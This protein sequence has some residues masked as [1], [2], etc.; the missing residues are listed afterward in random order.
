MVKSLPRAAATLTKRQLLSSRPQV[1]TTPV[2]SDATRPFQQFDLDTPFDD[3][4]GTAGDGEGIVEEE[5]D[6]TE[7]PGNLLSGVQSRQV[8]TQD[9]N[10][11]PLGFPRLALYK[12]QWSSTIFEISKASSEEDKLCLMGV[13]SRQWLKHGA[14]LLHLFSEL[15]V[16]GKLH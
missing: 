7:G 15:F 14:E 9:M 11:G 13:I 10:L 12:P 8:V 1:D 4:F 2:P 6:V 16:S 5:I 3:P